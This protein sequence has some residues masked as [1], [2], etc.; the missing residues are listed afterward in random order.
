MEQR[1]PRR[2]WRSPARAGHRPRV[3]IEDSHTPLRISDFSLFEQAGF[4]VAYCPGPGSDPAACPVLQGG[5]CPALEG[6][7]VVLHGLDPGFG[8]A[9]AIRRAHPDIP[10]VLEVERRPDGSLPE[11]PDGCVPLPYPSS[12]KGQIEALWRVLTDHTRQQRRS[13]P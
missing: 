7:D 2:S 12:V 1:I 8:I 4:D 3:L 5:P 13:A 6:A 11:V 9:A 10:V